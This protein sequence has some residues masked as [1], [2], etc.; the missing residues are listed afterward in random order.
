[1]LRA[2]LLIVAVPALL[3]ATQM[4]PRQ[5]VAAASASPTASASGPPAS[6]PSVAASAPSAGAPTPAPNAPSATITPSPAFSNKQLVGQPSTDW[7]TNGGNLYNQ[8]YSPL[9]AINRDNVTSLKGVWRTHLNGSGL[10]AHVLHC[11]S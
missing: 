11:L 7:I 1:M 2:S 10:G 8:R 4:L 9:T 3:L 5:A 6:A